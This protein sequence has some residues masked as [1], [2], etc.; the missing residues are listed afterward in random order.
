[1]KIF[2]CTFKLQTKQFYRIKYFC[3]EFMSFISVYIGTLVP[4][5]VKNGCYRKRGLILQCVFFFRYRPLKANK[6]EL[7]NIIEDFIKT[8]DYEEAYKRL[9]AENWMPRTMQHLKNKLEQRH[10][11]EHVK[12]SLFPPLL[13][14][15]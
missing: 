5:I 8:Q 1:M 2:P 7:K 13:F 9:L 11:K 3:Q 4:S 14:Q 12:Y 10:L 15:Q 6:E